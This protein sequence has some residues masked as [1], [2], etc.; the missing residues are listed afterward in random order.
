M[1]FRFQ[2][3]RTKFLT[4]GLAAVVL[5][6]SVNLIL[7][8]IERRRSAD[9]LRENAISIAQQTAFVSAPLVAFDS[10]AEID[11]AL[12][13]LRTD[14]NF[15]YA[16]VCGEGGLPL[17]SV[18]QIPGGPCPPTAGL[19]L[20]DRGGMLH[21]RMPIVD[22]GRTW[23]ILQL[24]VSEARHEKDEARTWGL[25]L[26]ASLLSMLVT[27]VSGLYLARSIAY[28]VSRL[29]EAVSRVRKGDWSVSVDVHSDDEV[30][31]LA[32]SFR[33]MVQEL[34]RSNAYIQDILQSMADSMIVFD[35]AGLIQTANPATYALLGYQSGSLIGQPIDQVTTHGSE[36][37][38]LGP[39]VLTRS[40]VETN[41]V[42]QNGQQ[43]PVNTSVARM[44]VGAG[45]ICMAQDLRE[46][47][48]SEIE[49]LMAKEAAEAANRAKSAFLAGMSHEIRT[50]LNAILGYSQ[51]MLRE[52]A[53]SSEA[54]RNLDTINSSGTH[55]LALINDIL[56]MSKIEAGHMTLN[57]SAFDIHELVEDV[58]LMFRQRAQ[59]KGLEFVVSI[60]PDC[61]RTVRS[62][63]GKIRQILI[64]LL[65]NAL[66]FTSAGTVRLTVT[67]QIRQEQ[68]WLLANVEDTGLG[69]AVEEQGGL[70]RP[71]AQ[72]QSGRT[73]QS[74]TGLGLAISRKFA[75]L[76]GGTL[77]VHS[78][79]GKGSLFSL[80]IPVE[81]AAADAVAGKSPKRQVIGLETPGEAPRVLIVDDEP[82]NRGWLK[83]LL[84]AIGFEVREAE[85]GAQ[86]I[87]CW[88]EWKPRVILM[89]IRMPVLDGLE[90]TRQ[91]RAEPEGQTPCI[92]A[93]T[94]SAMEGDQRLAWAA[95][96]SDFLSK[97]LPV[98]ELLTKL[99]THLNLA[100]R[101]AEDLP[102]GGG[103]PV[104]DVATLRE[105]PA[106]LLSQLQQA[107]R[108]GDKRLIDLLLEAVAERN[109]GCAAALKDLADGYE[110]D[111]IV[112]VL[113]ECSR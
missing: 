29:A 25:A 88:R 46:R 94:A 20:L 2:S 52:R 37:L 21:I 80:E 93:L 40:A 36:L 101:Y 105:L 16:R 87:E 108:N 6:G 86:G 38:S 39:G 28:P 85:D 33:S 79:L 81:I 23:G 12:R 68:L 50:P 10:R 77:G 17:A 91:I 73:L 26:G 66:K 102:A 100:Y 82:H 71:F 74:G 45:L 8:A 83:S 64:N 24:G 72:T 78:E 49:L 106:E 34:H 1:I 42:T 65:G 113:K 60:A 109:R 62:D 44:T 97:P 51:L 48:Q 3:I 67:Q 27:L 14:P 31:V 59:G 84:T 11:R 69:I 92:I 15:A 5:S 95:G 13:L 7:A 90:A 89:D 47:K 53:L 55:L 54:R 99:Q 30:G 41:Y 18:G 103:V 43:I 110:Y 32:A 57:P 22:G 61:P 75:R 112:Q 76:I 107:V 96:I 4:V 111:A 70:F 63:E 19:Q 56:D 58:A 98:E 9:Q 104:L 35:A